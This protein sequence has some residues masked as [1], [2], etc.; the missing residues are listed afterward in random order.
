MAT[1]RKIDT[2]WL[3]ANKLGHWIKPL[4]QLIAIF[5][6]VEDVLEDNEDAPEVWAMNLIEELRQMDA[7]EAGAKNRYV[8][9]AVV[10]CPLWRWQARVGTEHWQPLEETLM[11][12]SRRGNVVLW[13][14]GSP[15]LSVEEIEDWINRQILEDGPTG[16]A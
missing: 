13:Q 15:T 10:Q 9:M 6:G 16:V 5:E 4:S 3:R 11:D 7:P 1:L 14:K 2:R 12:F 8:H